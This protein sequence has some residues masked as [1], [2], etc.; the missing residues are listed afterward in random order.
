MSKEI[1]K[2]SNSGARNKGIRKGE[3]GIAMVTINGINIKEYGLICQPGHEH[4]LT[5][6]IENKTLQYPVK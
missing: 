3:V 1:D 4:P 2:L 5:A 6:V